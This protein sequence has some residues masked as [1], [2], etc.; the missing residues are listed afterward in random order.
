MFHFAFDDRGR[1]QV[2]EHRR[3]AVKEQ[4]LRLKTRKI[5]DDFYKWNKEFL[6]LCELLGIKAYITGEKQYPATQE[7]LCDTLA[8]GN[9]EKYVSEVVSWLHKDAFGRGFLTLPGSTSMEILHPAKF[10][11]L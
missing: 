3:Q 9:E 8:D 7:I 6:E 5:E 4:I 11:R 1:F 2:S 10:F